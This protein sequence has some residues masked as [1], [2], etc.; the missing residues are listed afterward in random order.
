M[1]GA[2]TRLFAALFLVSF[3]CY[4][5]IFLILGNPRIR[6]RLALDQVRLL[7]ILANILA[8]VGSV[9]FLGAMVLH[10][11]RSST[12]AASALADNQ[13]GEQAILNFLPF[14]I[15]PVI[16]GVFLIRRRRVREISTAAPLPRYFFTALFLLMLFMTFA[17][18]VLMHFS[19][20]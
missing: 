17:V 11:C 15:I 12:T 13:A 9:A 3:G 8:V 16:V 6:Q 7:R 4:A 14:I 18:H 10:F 5:L 19:R 2:D 20:D 1:I